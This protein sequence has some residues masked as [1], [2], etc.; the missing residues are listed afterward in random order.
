MENLENQCLEKLNI[1]LS[2]FD[3]KIEIAHLT[4]LNV[5][6]YR[7]VDNLSDK[8]EWLGLWLSVNEMLFHNISIFDCLKSYHII[9]NDFNLLS[10]A[11][12]NISS[13]YKR[14]SEAYQFLQ[15]LKSSSL[16]EFIIKCDLMEI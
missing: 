2:K 14:Y 9:V 8:T 16:E 4:S 5:W 6:Q 3:L 1:V 12:H 7:L 15:S 13:I 11:T 10:H